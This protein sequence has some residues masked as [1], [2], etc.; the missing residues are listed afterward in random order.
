MEQTF[1]KKVEEK[2]LSS[3]A[4]GEEQRESISVIADYVANDYESIVDLDTKLDELTESKRKVKSEFGNFLLQLLEV[5]DF[6]ERI[7]ALDT[8]DDVS[9]LLKRV[10]GGYKRLLEELSR[11]GVRQYEPNVGD[12]PSP[13]EDRVMGS[14]ENEKLSDGVI[15]KVIK[16]GYTWD[17]KIMR[18]SHVIT[19]KNR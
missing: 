5:V 7:L 11:I 4:S 1:L 17:D 9:S 10:E 18:E 8:E 19:V 2:P 6:F 13:K 15:C 3:W 16:K 14:E 12:N